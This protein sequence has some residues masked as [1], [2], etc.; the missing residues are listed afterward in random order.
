MLTVMK[1]IECIIKH[2]KSWGSST[3]IH[4]RA[5]I[6]RMVVPGNKQE[7]PRTLLGLHQRSAYA[8]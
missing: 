3:G 8:P 1:A 7:K 6:I 2:V 5:N 4:T